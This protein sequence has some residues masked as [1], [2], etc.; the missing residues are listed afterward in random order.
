MAIGKRNGADQT[1]SFFC[2]QFTD[3]VKHTPP[4]TKGVEIYCR[5]VYTERKYSAPPGGKRP[6]RRNLPAIRRPAVPHGKRD[7]VPN[8]IIIPCG[9]KKDKD[10]FGISLH[11]VHG[12]PH[13]SAGIAE[14][15][16]TSTAKILKIL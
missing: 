16:G 8:N 4:P 6:A 3:D 7:S 1:D 10:S 12:F 14:G 11:F 9:E 5:M 13:F 2:K 15:A